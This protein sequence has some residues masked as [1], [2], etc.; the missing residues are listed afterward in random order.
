MGDIGTHAKIAKEVIA[1]LTSARPN[2]EYIFFEVGNWFTDTSQMRDPFAHVSGKIAVWTVAHET[3]KGENALANLQ[4]L[5]DLVLDKS[6]DLDSYLN[7]LMGL[8][9]PAGGLLAS[10][11]LDVFFIW[12]LE[13]FR[14]QGVDPD[15]FQ[16]LFL[17]STTDRIGTR[18]AIMSQY[19]PHEH[20]DFPPWPYHNILGERNASGVVE[21][22]CA[23]KPRSGGGRKLYQY[24]ED[25]LVYISDLLTLIEH[26]WARQLSRDG[27]TDEQKRDRHYL[28]T[29]FGHAS[30][31]IEDFFFHSNFVE[32]AWNSLGSPLPDQSS[33][34]DSEERDPSEDQMTPEKEQRVFQRRLRA[35]CGKGDVLDTKT[36]DP[37]NEVFT[38]YFASKDMFHTIMDAI[39]GLIARANMHGHVPDALSSMIKSFLPDVDQ[40]T[41]DPKQRKQ[42][43]KNR[44]AQQKANLDNGVYVTAAQAAQAAGVLHPKS[45]ERV[46]SMCQKDLDLWNKY[47]KVDLGI[48]GFVM[49]ILD[50][51][52]AEHLASDKRGA[53]MDALPPGAQTDDG[54]DPLVSTDNGASSEN[55]G[56]HTLL[57][58]D[59]ERKRPLRQEA[60]NLACGTAL[61]VAQTM[62]SEWNKKHPVARSTSSD[63]AV[64]TLNLDNLDWL[65]LL[66]HFVCH[67]S[68]AAFTK[69]GIQWWQAQ[70]KKPDP[71]QTGHDYQTIDDGEAQTRMMETMRSTLEA[72]YTA[73]AEDAE[74][75]WRSILST[76][77]HEETGALIGGIA[78][79]VL[80]AVAG[81][82]AGAAVGS[83]FGPAGAIVGAIVGGIL[84]AV[85]GGVLGALT[86]GA[87]GNMF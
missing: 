72:K 77:S 84:G 85:I 19:W 3:A 69:A 50:Q 6:Y 39:K 54:R 74:A 67:P 16:E 18:T 78:G 58:K 81:A 21:H 45:V 31:A 2:E 41:T 49:Q 13:Q 73:L 30:H 42:N 1:L 60:F 79:A 23:K 38:G 64:N 65:H 46:K 4:L 71:N 70:I 27:E 33:A 24:T 75:E 52:E 80:G 44:I 86:G 11:F 17:P 35:P 53:D 61:F 56:S 82:M 55:I 15:E 8:P 68:E 76:V 57:A 9:G 63:P 37:M 20:V 43:L 12:G 34:P 87:I 7:E 40:G 26:K 28:I 25:Q 32:T 59:S 83:A 22:D 14:R 66:Q 29:R 62:V 10:Y 48:S 5:A 51:A 36:S 47:P